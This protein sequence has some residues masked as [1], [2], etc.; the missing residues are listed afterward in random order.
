MR[1]LAAAFGATVVV[2]SIGFVAL[3]AAGA[4]PSETP[5][6]AELLLN[7]D[8][9][10]EADLT[11]DGDLYRKMSLFEKLR[12]LEALKFLESQSQAPTPAT[13]TPRESKPR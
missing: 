8:L 13:P 9:L 4:A 11:R 2:A 12:M 3:G 6:D 10:K 7:L 5:P 1:L